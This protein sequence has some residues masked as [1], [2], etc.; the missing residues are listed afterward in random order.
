[1]SNILERIAQL[2]D[3]IVNIER[4]ISKLEMATSSDGDD[5]LGTIRSVYNDLMENNIWNSL[6]FIANLSHDSIGLNDQQK[7]EFLDPVPIIPSRKIYTKE[8]IISI[9]KNIQEL[10]IAKPLFNN[11]RIVNI[12]NKS[13]SNKSPKSGTKEKSCNLLPS[14]V[15]PTA[16]WNASPSNQSKSEFRFGLVVE[17]PDSDSTES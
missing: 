1:M 6:D 11:I 13:K 8:D 10:C 4:R 14:R 3:R 9:G 5:N 17:Y 7:N 15:S 12:G 16:I 2:E